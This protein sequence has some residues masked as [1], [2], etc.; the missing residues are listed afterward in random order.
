MK[1]SILFLIIIYVSCTSYKPLYWDV[2]KRIQINCNIYGDTL[3]TFEN[4]YYGNNSGSD[5]NKATFFLSIEE[6]QKI[7]NEVKK[8]NYFGLPDTISRLKIE[9]ND[10]ESLVILENML[11]QFCVLELDGKRKLIF[12]YNFKNMDTEES[13][14]FEEIMNVIYNIVEKRNDLKKFH[15]GN[16]WI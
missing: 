7:I 3:N 1:Y 13:L 14:R 10:K 11:T 4:Y 12:M 2:E 8:N 6:Q 16:W 15:K 9:P 5:D